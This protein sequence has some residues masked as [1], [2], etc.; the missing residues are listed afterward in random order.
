MAMATD[1]KIDAQSWGMLGLLGLIWGAS[2]FFTGVAAQELPALLIVFARVGL[3]G[4]ILIPLHLI[5]QGPLPR[6]AKTWIAAG[7]MSLLNNVLPFT[8][9]AWGQHYIGSGLAS[10]V[11]STTPMFAAGFMALFSLEKLTARKAVAL[12]LGL[13]GV[14]ILKGGNFGDLG[15]QTL[16]ILAVTFAS[17]SYGLSTVWSKKRLIGIPPLTTATCQLIT[18]GLVM[19]VLAFGFS[20]PALYLS[21]PWHVLLAL[22]A[23]AAIATALAYLLFFWLINRAGPSFVTLVTMLV[24]VSAIILG[25]LFLGEKLTFN[26]IA[27]A[28]IIGSALVIIDGRALEK[29]GLT[30]PAPAARP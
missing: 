1:Q 28:V 6:D 9:I 27:G 2:F 20:T 8:A 15:E 12:A 22:L 29:L 7:G 21:A 18:S 14:V 13:F 23:S 5:I 24:P 10:V 19:S 25:A 11:N 16:G 17:A 4:L 3:A 26:E 30:K